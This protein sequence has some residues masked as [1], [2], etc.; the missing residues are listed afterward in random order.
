M[1]SIFK[2]QTLFETLT[3]KRVMDETAQKWLDEIYTK[4]I[5]PKDY[6]NYLLN[7]D[8]YIDYKVLEFKITYFNRVGYYLSEETIDKFKAEC[9]GKIVDINICVSNTEEF[10]EKYTVA[11]K[12]MSENYGIDNTYLNIFLKKFQTDSTY[13][14][15]NLEQEFKLLEQK[16]DN[17]I[18]SNTKVTP[19]KSN[20]NI[21]P[22][23]F[24]ST[25]KCSPS[26]EDLVILQDMDL[27]LAIA[28]EKQPPR[29]DNEIF[30]HV[31]GRPMYVEEYFKYVKFQ[32]IS[33]NMKQEY[34]EGLLK[35]H[36]LNFSRLSQIIMSFQ[37]DPFDDYDY[38]M[39]FLFEIDNPTFFDTIV[40]KILDSDQYNQ[41][42]KKHVSQTYE[43]L[44]S[45]N[46][47]KSEIEY[48]F[49]IV[50][51]K[52]LGIYDESLHVYLVDFKKESDDI[53]E[54]ISNVYQRVLERNPDHFEHD[55]YSEMYRAN[56][57]I[58]VSN[59]KLEPILIQSLEFHDILKH[60]ITDI[61]CDKYTTNSIPPSVLY[62][63]LDVLIKKIHM[64]TLD[65]LASII[66]SI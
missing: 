20:T 42:M 16:R 1:S 26:K 10:I 6:T 9:I 25:F 49:R 54:N 38:V 58:Q 36:V 34:Y 5:Q 43:K 53:L 27:L 62:S 65:N 21:L 24:E 47:N 18:I 48:I 14:F 11:I 51:A 61:Y 31:F 4:S 40:D 63:T 41:C 2:L 7:T 19:I 13:T 46:L 57:N 3:N 8:E 28:T 60:K 55:M 35:T 56:N 50:K 32:K 59:S 15:D 52:K 39:N 23:L 45:T 17:T 30:Y 64:I 12:A 22:D 66:Q 29:S 33:N 37:T 44:F